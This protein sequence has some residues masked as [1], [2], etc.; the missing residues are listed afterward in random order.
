VIAEA[1][2]I[3]LAVSLT[4]GNRNDVTQAW[5]PRLGITTREVIAAVFGGSDDAVLPG[6]MS[7]DDW[8]QQGPCSSMTHHVT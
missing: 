3:P 2:G 7:E 1:H 5:A 4:G 8:W 6:R